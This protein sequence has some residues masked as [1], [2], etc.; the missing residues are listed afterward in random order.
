MDN[1]KR[2]KTKYNSSRV[3]D[4]VVTGG[5]H[6]SAKNP[7]INRARTYQPAPNNRIGNFRTTEGFHA[8]A[9]PSVPQM[10]KPLG[11]QPARESPGR[12]D[13]QLPESSAKSK[14]I[15]K[16]RN[17][18][19]I[20]LKSLV[21]LLFFGLIGGGYLFGKGFLTA[22]QVFSGG[23]SAIWG[24]V[25]PSKLRGEG[26]GRV[27]ILLL[28][29]GGSGHE[30]EDLTD[31]LMIASIDPVHKEAALLSIPRDL[32]V[33]SAHGYT[34]INSVYANAKLAVLNGQETNDQKNRA[35]S[36]GLEA[37]SKVVEDHMGVPVHYYVI[38][39]FKGFERAI[40]EVG[41][42]QVKS[43]E[44][45]YENMIINGR[46]YV[47][48]VKEGNQKMDGKK[49]LAFSRS[50]MSSTRGDFAR[51]DRQRS[52][53]LG[54]KDKVLSGGTF[55]NPKKVSGLI[56]AFGNNMRANL[57]TGEVMRLYELGNEIPQSKIQSISLASENDSYVRTAMLGGQS[58]VVPRVGVNDYSEIRGFVRNKLKDGFI[59][60]ENATIA[61]YNGT[62]IPG[63][64]GSRSADL[65]SYGYNISTVADAPTKGYKHTVLIDLRNGKKKYTKRYL[66]KRLKTTAVSSMPNNS[67]DPGEADFV[68]ILGQNEGD[69]Y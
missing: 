18:R 69:N 8:R 54:L 64:A 11:R 57:D 53:L 14:G 1:L 32:Y 46:S 61:V 13:M 36:S 47:L 59:R 52:V 34:K 30:G 15:G 65:K 25:D 28:G 24:N 50:R 7:T 38:I 9:R 63:L 66:E 49:A 68:I 60:S 3:I 33:N 41:G 27:N 26:D 5:A 17:V 22:R 39:D 31:T 37:V 62:E 16:K 67:I 35:E 45:I 40:N 56:D 42:I 12:I 55:S 51:G 58:V 20:M 10:Q 43:D 2:I 4:G 19:K 44:A 48:N 23:G 6:L 21:A 29:K